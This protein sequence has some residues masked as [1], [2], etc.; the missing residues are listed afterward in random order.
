MTQDVSFGASNSESNYGSE[1]A[2]ALSVS[3]A[4]PLHGV[5]NGVTITGSLLQ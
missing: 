2:L 3:I 5:I 1:S 4:D